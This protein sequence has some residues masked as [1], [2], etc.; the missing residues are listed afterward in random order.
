MRKQDTL[1][2][3]W[4]LLRILIQNLLTSAFLIVRFWSSTK[5]L[6]CG[7]YAD[8][9]LL[10]ASHRMQPISNFIRKFS[11]LVIY[12][13]SKTAMSVNKLRKKLGSC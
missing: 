3:A 6:L 1:D 8:V 2:Y 13:D 5:P 7:W 12:L 9:S 4:P 11:A 10:C